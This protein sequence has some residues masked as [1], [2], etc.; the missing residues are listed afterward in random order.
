M[1]STLGGSREG[2]QL[3]ERGEIKAGMSFVNSKLKI[4][5]RYVVSTLG[6]HSQLH[7]GIHQGLE[8]LLIL[9]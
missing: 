1:C 5:W 7:I 2:W 4:H 3:I 6:A 8:E 9:I